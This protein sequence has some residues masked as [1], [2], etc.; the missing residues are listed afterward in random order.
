EFDRE[1][2]EHLGTSRIIVHITNPSG[3]GKDQEIAFITINSI[4][5]DCSCPEGKVMLNETS[6]RYIFK[7]E[8]IHCFHLNCSVFIQLAEP[9]RHTHRLQ[10]SP[11]YYDTKPSDIF[12]IQ[13]GISSPM[14]MRNIPRSPFYVSIHPSIL[15]F[16]NEATKPT[17]DYVAVSLLPI[18]EKEMEICG[19]PQFDPTLTILVDPTCPAMDCV[20]NLPKIVY[21]KIPTIEVESNSTYD[22][23]GLWLTSTYESRVRREQ[24][25]HG[26]FE[27]LYMPG[28]TKVEVSHVVLHYHRMWKRQPYLGDVES[29]PT[30]YKVKLSS[31]YNVTSYENDCDCAN[32]TIKVDPSSERVFSS[33]RYPLHYCNSL[34]CRTTFEAPAG[35]KVVFRPHHLSL[36]KGSD[37][38]RLFDLIDGKEVARERYT[39]SYMDGFTTESRTNMLL[40]VFSS[41]GF[42][43]Y[44]GFNASVYAAKLNDGEGDDYFDDGST[45]MKGG[46]FWT[47]LFFLIVVAG[48]AAGIV[49]MRRS[50]RPIA[51]SFAPVSF[52]SGG[53]YDDGSVHFSS[54]ST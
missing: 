40:A 34:V 39:G 44:E 17:K 21:D 32:A 2:K 54:F 37:F 19:C 20:W 46:H 41:D 47:V 38:L 10:A 29:G 16:W 49:H 9:L 23:D 4:V 31:H 33:P 8:K 30:Y 43:T 53:D 51:L 15:L 6:S 52:H 1:L 11:T 50:S 24:L 42:I 28:E 27:V 26:S 35:Y 45:E 12:A 48:I 3:Y 7:M 25:M 18:S 5:D 13:D 14:N 22:Y 36:Q